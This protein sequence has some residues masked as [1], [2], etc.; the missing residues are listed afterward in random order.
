[1]LLVEPATRVVPLAGVAVL[2]VLLEEL[3]LLSVPML[4]VGLVGVLRVTVDPE[5]VPV[6]RL[7][8]EPELLSVPMLRVG[9]VG[10]LRVTV[11]PEPVP[12][13]R[14][15][16]EPEVVPVLRLTLEPLLVVPRP[17]RV[18][19]VPRLGVWRETEGEELETEELE[20]AGADALVER[21]TEGEEVVRA[22]EPEGAVVLRLTLEP[23]VV[24]PL[25]PRD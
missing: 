8:E 15:T 7:T 9:L 1:M 17:L 13:L 24:R 20:R 14:L 2:A 11:D 23:L 16:E 5:P 22:E 4:R 18:T 21:L 25:P 6:L 3:E 12:V 19:V 10:V